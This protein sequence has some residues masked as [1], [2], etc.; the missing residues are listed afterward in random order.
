M[1]KVIQTL[2]VVKTVVKSEQQEV[3][4]DKF[5]P[6]PCLKSEA[7]ILYRCR[8]NSIIKCIESF[9]TKESISMVTESCEG[10]DLWTYM[11]NRNIVTFNENRLREIV[12]RIAE[13][14]EYIHSKGIVHHNLKLENILM[15]DNT[16]QA[17]P[18]I[19]D[20]SQAK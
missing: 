20:F 1:H 7:A 4:R 11:M 16:D 8:H 2:V 9:E 15:S 19:C 18:V 17:I 13:G 3:V 5:S 10:G 14:L 6:K 12:R